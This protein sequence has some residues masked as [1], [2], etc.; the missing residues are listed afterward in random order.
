HRTLNVPENASE[1][2]IRA[3]Y[4]TLARKWHPDRFQEGP[5]RAWAEKQMIEINQA[6]NALINRCKFSP[7]ASPAQRFK[8]VR[9]LIEAGQLSR[10]RHLMC[11]MDERSAEWNYHFGQMLL[12]RKDY[13]KAVVYFGIAV[14][15]APDNPEY[16]RILE[17][18]ESHL[19]KNPLGGVLKKIR[20]FHLPGRGKR[21]TFQKNR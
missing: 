2:D 9:L 12:K 7:P 13:E 14:R 21:P 6:Y 16:K 11:A 17:K 19:N 10:A 15:Q 3:A 18:A 4:R 1:A 5:E 8:E 20:S